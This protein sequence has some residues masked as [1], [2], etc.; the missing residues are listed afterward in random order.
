MSLAPS[1]RHPLLDPQIL[2]RGLV[3][4]VTMVAIGWLM[5]TIGLKAMLDSAWIDHEI[6]GQGLTGEMLLVGLGAVLVALGLPRQGVS[7]AAGYAFG[8]WMGMALALA[9]TLLGSL[10]TF[11]YA[12]FIGRDALSR[13]FPDRIDRINR[14]L[15]GNEL[16]MALILRLS[17]ISHNGVANVAAGV[18]GIRVLPFFAGSL[19]G[20]V[21][22]TV[23]FVLVG[24][25]FELNKTLS[26]TLSALL[27]IL[28]TILGLW[29]WRRV[30][31]SRGL[32]EEEG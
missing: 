9:A 8:F 17:P 4:I 12:R 14:F 11:Y 20:Y 7:F 19:L 6:K 32:A 15:A 26:W 25:G 31:K 21:P 16:T 1:K 30:Q 24:A 18:S 2:L 5:E 23:I 10:V 29:L 13:R 3:L 27:F 28:S 22:Q